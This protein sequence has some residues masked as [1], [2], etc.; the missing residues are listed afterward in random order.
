MQKPD[1]AILALRLRYANGE[2]TDEQFR[3]MSAVLEA[4]AP[5]AP[6]DPKIE[7]NEKPLADALGLKVYS[8]YLSYADEKVNF[9]HVPYEDVISI[10]GFAMHSSTNYIDRSNLSSFYIGLTQNR[11]IHM[12]SQ[13]SYIGE[14]IH[15]QIAQTVGLVQAKTFHFRLKR[16]V[17]KLKSDGELILSQGFSDTPRTTLTSDGRFISGNRSY[18]I[19]SCAAN[20]ILLIGT[21]YRA[22]IGASRAHRP[23]E[24]VISEKKGFFGRVPSNALHY[25]PVTDVD[26]VHTL[27]EAFARPDESCR[28]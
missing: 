10:V 6:S 7:A 12:E 8:T 18:D 23:A 4:N 15:K 25:T 22:L 17:E 27:V 9:L 21:R 24:I 28:T 16:S 26:V 3:S 1:N 14:S 11:I 13:K 19:A 5:T 20:G 2:L